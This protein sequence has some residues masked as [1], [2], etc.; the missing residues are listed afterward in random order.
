MESKDFYH[1]AIQ[2][3]NDIKNIEPQLVS[4][5]DSEFCLLKT[6][7]QM[8]YAGVTSVRIRNGQ[9]MRACPEFNAVMTMIASGETTVEELITVSFRSKEVSQPCPEC[10]KLL[11]DTDPENKDTEIYVAP[12]Q[13]VK[14]SELLSPGAANAQKTQPENSQKP[15]ISEKSGNP[16]KQSLTGFA[17]VS[18]NVPPPAAM[19]QAPKNPLPSANDFAGFATDGEMGDFGFEAAETPEEPEEQTENE[20]EEKVAANQDN[21]FYAPPAP[22]NPAPNIMQPG[23]YP[24]SQP[25]QP[26]QQSYYQQQIAQPYPQQA[27]APN[28]YYYN[29]P[30]AQPQP[31]PQPYG[32]QTSAPASYYYQQPPQQQSMYFNQPPQQQSVYF[33]QPANHSQTVSN[34]YGQAQPQSS[35]YAS[36]MA[37]T[38]R[39][40]EKSAFK[41]RLANF[42]DDD[43]D[44][45]GADSG[46]NGTISREETLR[47]AKERKKQAKQD[48]RKNKRGF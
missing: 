5:S 37:P 1:Q 21:P 10:L 30:Y 16:A 35:Y 43:T 47:L 20:F 42:I 2:F 33:N 22:Q 4:G 29:Q 24:Q 41:N 19:S 23:G 36:Q 25:Q 45:V 15:E 6:D 31:Y 13:H 34:Y 28:S 46:E 39:K 38:A 7:K 40:T 27:G 8:I 17:A 44:A 14:A 12:N 9:I 3:M 11:C 26:M 18:E 32:Q 48:A